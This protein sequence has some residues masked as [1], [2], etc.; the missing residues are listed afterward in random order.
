[1]AMHD[2]RATDLWKNPQGKRV[3]ALSPDAPRFAENAHAEVPMKELPIFRP[4]GYQ[5]CPNASSHV[6]RELERIA[7]CPADKTV[8]AKHRRDN[9]KDATRLADNARDLL[10]YAKPAINGHSDEP[11]AESAARSA[12]TECEMSKRVA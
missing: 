9:V 1:M 11:V 8:R 2:V 3:L 4:K 6:A 12:A 7:F 10:C 5:G